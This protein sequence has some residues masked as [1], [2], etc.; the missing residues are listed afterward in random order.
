MLMEPMQHT[1][2]QLVAIS[3]SQMEW[4]DYGK[5]LFHVVKIT[6]LC[7]LIVLARI[8]DYFMYIKWMLKACSMN[9]EIFM[10]QPIG[11]VIFG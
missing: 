9:E 11:Y 1:L 8:Y 6:S 3:F 7:I 2:A 10:Q 4:F 5:K